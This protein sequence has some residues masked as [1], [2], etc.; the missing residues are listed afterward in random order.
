MAEIPAVAF[1]AAGIFVDVFSV[2]IGMNSTFGRF[3]VFLAFGT[4][5]IAYGVYKLIFPTETNK[6]PRN[7]AYLEDYIAQKRKEYDAVNPQQMPYMAQ[8][9]VV[10]P[11]YPTQYRQVPPNYQQGQPVTPY[12]NRSGMNQPVN[13][14]NR[15]YNNRR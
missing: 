5:L 7:P 9:T 4:V 12:P 13:P 15:P 1:I 10:Q 14:Y 8:Q 2:Y 11:Q 3:I 6:T